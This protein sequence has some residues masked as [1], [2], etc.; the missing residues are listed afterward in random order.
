MNIMQAVREFHEK[1]GFAV[2]SSL[3]GDRLPMAYGHETS[4][5]EQ[6]KAVSIILH[7][8]ANGWENGTISKSVKGVL[9]ETFDLR[10]MRGHLIDEESGE[11]HQGLAERDEVKTLDALADLLYVVVGT[12]VSYGLPLDRAFYEVHKSNMTK[13][14]KAGGEDDLRCRNKG[15][16]YVPPDLKHLL[17][18]FR[19]YGEVPRCPEC[20]EMIGKPHLPNCASGTYSE[21]EYVDPMS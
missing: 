16:S 21:P 1:H 7:H 12:A 19:E 15:A 17:A 20:D 3:A 5:D 11:L 18:V 14:V 4:A 13:A 6:L 9:G 10:L 2:N 8:F